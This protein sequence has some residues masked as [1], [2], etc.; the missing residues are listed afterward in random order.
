MGTR[1]PVWKT[2]PMSRNGQEQSGLGKG[3]LSYQVWP[4]DG[5]DCCQ[6]FIWLGHQAGMERGAGAPR[7]NNMDFPACLAG[8]R[9]GVDFD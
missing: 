1:A 4:L 3:V 2:M 6:C 8:Q 9:L 5:R 7:M